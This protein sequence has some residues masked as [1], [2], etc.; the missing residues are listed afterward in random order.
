LMRFAV[1]LTACLLAMPEMATAQERDPAIDAKRR[2]LEAVEARLDELE[3]DLDARRGS[4]DALVGE[5][6]GLERDIAQLARAGHQLTAMIQEQTR[7]VARLEQRLDSE[8]R[9]LGRERSVLAGL[10]RSVHAL[11]GAERIRLLLD[12]E[13]VARTGRVLSYYSYLNGYRLR[14]IEAIAARAQRLEALRQEAS[15]ETQRLATLA[16]SQ[17][18]TRRR[19]AKAQTLRS[20][21]L[22]GLEQTIATRE[23]RLSSLRED[24]MGLRALIEQLERRAMALP[25][26]DL[27]QEPI[28]R[29]RGQLRWPLKRTRLLHRFGRKKGDSGQRW[30][31]VVLAAKEGTDVRAVY[32][33]RIVYADWLRGFGLLTIIEH[34]EEYMTL[35][36][37]NQTLLKE[38]GEWVGAGDLI[39]LSGASG[40]QR[41]PGLYFA[42]RHS[43]RP[44][45]PEAWCASRADLDTRAGS[46][47]E[48]S[49]AAER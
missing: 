47:P 33:G 16:A 5:L 29:R 34:D 9:A 15:E 49:V 11:G 2:D 42:I 10:L 1:A 18:E 38:Q 20:H 21:L 39:A 27:Q 46:S 3:Q 17:E 37:H 35:Y 28:S 32:H 7:A 4:R 12:Q 19:L 48:P 40:G 43:G 31:G 23:Q 24:A 13:D 41:A 22:V 14:R 30:D 25:E 26:A 8:R 44:V 6:E 45:D 36:G